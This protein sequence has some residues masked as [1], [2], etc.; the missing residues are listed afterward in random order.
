MKK[1]NPWENSKTFIQET[2]SLPNFIEFL[3]RNNITNTSRSCKTEETKD[4]DDSGKDK[5]IVNDFNENINK[6]DSEEL[7]LLNSL[8][9]ISKMYYEVVDLYLTLIT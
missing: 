1:F 5:D 4:D 9:N 7:V 2:G 8:N 3:S 6:N